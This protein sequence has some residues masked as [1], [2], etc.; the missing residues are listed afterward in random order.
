M[1]WLEICV[2]RSYSDSKHQMTITST[3]SVLELQCFLVEYLSEFSFSH[4]VDPKLVR[5][6][7][8]INVTPVIIG[9]EEK[10]TQLPLRIT[11]LNIDDTKL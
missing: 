3:Q 1:Y 10:G 5:R 7:A 2:R 4:V 8:A 6:K 9:E 11:R